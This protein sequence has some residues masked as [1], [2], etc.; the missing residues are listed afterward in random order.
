MKDR[1]STSRLRKKECTNLRATGS[2]RRWYISDVSARGMVDKASARV[3]GS[4]MGKGF[5]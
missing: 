5:S 3:I 1:K 2:D 4:E